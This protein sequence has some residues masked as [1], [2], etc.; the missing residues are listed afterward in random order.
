MNLATFDNASELHK[1]ATLHPECRL[2]VR[3]AVDDSSS[4]CK[5]SNKFGCDVTTAS[6]LLQ[7]AKE[8]SL[9]VVG[10][11]FHV[12]SGCMDGEVFRN[13]IRDSRLVFNA[14]LDHGYRFG[15]ILKLELMN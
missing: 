12:G 5:L 15:R 8:L 3:I 4:L 13:A 9:E 10:V 6:Q 1:H 7:L 11:S 2:V 14:A